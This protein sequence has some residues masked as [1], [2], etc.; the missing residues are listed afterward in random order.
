MP[1]IPW[2]Q[3]MSPPTFAERFNL[4]GLA[5]RVGFGRGTTL[6][7]QKSVEEYVN[8]IR[9]MIKDNKYV[10]TANINFKETGPIPNFLKAKELV[11]A[12]VGESFDVLY[13]RNIKKRKDIKRWQDPEK[14]RI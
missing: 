10:P 9:N 5:G 8:I 1:Y 7:S 14:K 3:R 13:N 12:E 11:K 2:W 6:A 4:G